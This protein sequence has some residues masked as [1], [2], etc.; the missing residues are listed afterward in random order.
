MITQDL[1]PYVSTA[2]QAPIQFLGIP[3]VLRATGQTTNG[4]FGLI[5]HL[6][7][8]PGFASPYHTH[9]SED[10]S[11][12]ILEGEMA[13]CCGGKWMMAG[14]GA[15]VFLPRDVPHGFRIQGDAP[16]RLL[17][18]CSPG[19]FE[20]LVVEMSEAHHAPMAEVA[21]KYNIDVHGALP[22]ESMGAIS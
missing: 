8:R 4:A 18:L 2:D 16:A 11:F 19:G 22:L 3:T 17:L 20:R 13:V 6:A 1:Q 14:A 10:E 7:V 9:H 21:A 12:Y 5:E 15:F